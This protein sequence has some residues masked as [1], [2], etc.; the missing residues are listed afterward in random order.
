QARRTPVDENDFSDYIKIHLEEIVRRRG[1][2]INREVELRRP[3]AGATGERTDIHVDAFVRDKQGEPSE[4]ITVIIETKG[5]WHRQ[6][7]KAMESQLVTRYL[8]DN[9]CRHGLYLVGWF[10][11]PQWSPQP[12]PAPPSWSLAEARALFTDQARALS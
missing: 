6:L 7:Q 12:R 9:Q 1:I 11:S 8:H 5:S 3:T 2:V 4:I 10:N